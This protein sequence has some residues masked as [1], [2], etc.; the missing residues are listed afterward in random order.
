MGTP[1]LGLYQPRALRAVAPPHTLRDGDAS[2][3]SESAVGCVGVWILHPPSATPTH[4]SLNY[5]N[6]N[7]L[8][9]HTSRRV[10]A[11]VLTCSITL[12]TGRIGSVTLYM[13]FM[14]GTVR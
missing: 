11:S 13:L 12:D 10:A 8:L 7:P 2:L 3:V 4:L 5:S 14:P 6:R 9:N 1:T